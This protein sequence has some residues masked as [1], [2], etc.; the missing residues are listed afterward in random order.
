[1]HEMRPLCPSAGLGAGC[2]QDSI[3]TDTRDQGDWTLPE[4]RGGSCLGTVPSGGPGLGGCWPCWA[5][6]GG[7]FRGVGSSWGHASVCP[8]LSGEREVLPL[9]SPGLGPATPAPDRELPSCQHDRI[10]PRPSE[11]LIQAPVGRGTDRGLHTSLRG[12]DVR[13]GTGR[14]PAGWPWGGHHGPGSHLALGDPTRQGEPGV[15]S[16]CW[17]LGLPTLCFSHTLAI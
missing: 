5:L 3:L 10:T 17:F 13:L 12:P 8:S 6:F 16:V 11:V 9:D 7:H 14:G 15:P 2:S 1:M 4:G